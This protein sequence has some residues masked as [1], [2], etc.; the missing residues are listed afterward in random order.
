[1]LSARNRLDIV[2]WRTCV[3]IASFAAK[4]DEPP[5]MN[6]DAGTEIENAAREF[7]GRLVGAAVEP[8]QALF[9]V[10]ISAA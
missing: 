4:C 7:P 10:G 8:R 3:E 5:D 6:V 1:V 2:V 9:I